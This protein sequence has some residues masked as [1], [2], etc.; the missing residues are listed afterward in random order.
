MHPWYR[1]FGTND[2]QPEPSDLLEHLQGLGHEVR[3]HF[4]GDDQGWFDASLVHPTSGEFQLERFLAGEE[5]IRAQLNTWAAWLESIEHEESGR[6]MQLI[7]GARQL[8]TLHG[9]EDREGDEDETFCT[10]ICH[11][12]CRVTE[13]IYQV[14]GQGFLSA[15]GKF[16]VEE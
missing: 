3:S 15:E 4:R 8:F 14:D 9:P 13:G 7:I 1:I 10:E 12:L 2:A 6:L 5:G 11:F 16:L